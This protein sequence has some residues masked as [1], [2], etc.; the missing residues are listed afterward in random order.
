MAWLVTIVSGLVVGVIL[1][2]YGYY[3]KKRARN[4]IGSAVS[5][6]S[7]NVSGLWIDVVNSAVEK[8]CKQ[9]RVKLEAIPQLKVQDDIAT[10]T[11]RTWVNGNFRYYDLKVN[12]D[13]DILEIQ[14]H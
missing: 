1:F 13:G 4:R 2:E 9:E 11:A 6:Q 8:L 10:V 3:R 14:T 5:K 12:K 7:S